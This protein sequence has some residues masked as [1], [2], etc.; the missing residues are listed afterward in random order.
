MSVADEPVT[1]QDLLNAV[2]DLKSYVDDLKSYVDERSEKVETRL[3]SAFHG[4]AR[5]MEIKVRGVSTITG[6][7]DERL[8]L[9]EER[10]SDLERK[11][12]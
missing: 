11:A 1:K 8:S 2:A 4:W 10:V 3:L 6:G 12:S 5:S 9:V 7:F